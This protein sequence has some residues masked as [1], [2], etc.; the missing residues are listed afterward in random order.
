MAK[1][2]A[3]KVSAPR[4]K[5]EA[6]DT[7]PEVTVKVLAHLHENGTGLAPGDEF[8]TTAARAS[9]LGDTVQIVTSE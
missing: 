8:I 9:A 2:A 7:S 3:T 5:G 1:K 6:P 4:K